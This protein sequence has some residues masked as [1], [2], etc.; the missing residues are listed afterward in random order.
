[1]TTSELIKQLRESV[2]ASQQQTAT[3]LGMARATYAT[4]EDGREPK[5]KELQGLTK[6]YNVTLDELATGVLSVSSQKT[7]PVVFG[8]D[9][10]ILPRDLSPEIH[11]AKLREVLLYI[12]NKIS[13][14][15]NVGETVLYKL[16]YFIDFD[17][18]EKFGRSIT[19]LT[20][21]KL[22]HGPVPQQASFQSVIAGMKDNQDI[23]IVTTKYFSYDQKKYLPLRTLGEITLTHL[24]AVELEH[25][26]WEIDRLS[27]K[28]ATQLS[29][30]AH[31]DTP[32]LATETGKPVD[33]QL[34]FYRSAPTAVTEPEDEL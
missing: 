18:Y 13:A 26:N 29:A 33:Y 17:F 6:L 22:E 7:A 3:K 23:E 24:S 8:G 1:M 20:Y 12:T 10:T 21:V 11:P 14:K 2:K 31:L 28:T 9:P 19:G 34:V 32:W 4:L 30:F 27:D 16:L 25:I 5:L 15:A